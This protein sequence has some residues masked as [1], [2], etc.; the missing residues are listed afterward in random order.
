[1]IASTSQRPPV[2]APRV[3]GS[4]CRQVWAA[5]GVPARLG[6]IVATG[7]SN[8]GSR[9]WAASTPNVSVSTVL[10]IEKT[11]LRVGPRRCSSDHGL[12]G[13]PHLQVRGLWA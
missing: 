4:S 11:S 1:M 9:R 5:A 6:S 13:Y 3:I 7:A 12:A 8:G 10:V 2:A